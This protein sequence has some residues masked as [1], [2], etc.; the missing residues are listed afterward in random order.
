M[1]DEISSLAEGILDRVM[2]DSVAQLVGQDVYAALAAAKGE[3]FE[4]SDQLSVNLLLGL[5]S[6]LNTLGEDLVE[7][8]QYIKAEL[9]GVM[10]N[11]ILAL[12]AELNWHH[13]MRYLSMAHQAAVEI[14]VAA[15]ST[16]DLIECDK[17][18]NDHGD[19]AFMRG[20]AKGIADAKIAAAKKGAIAR[21]EKYNKLRECFFNWYDAQPASLSESARIE[22]FRREHF[23]L[24]DGRYQW[25]EAV[26]KG[27][28][29]SYNEFP[30]TAKKWLEMRRK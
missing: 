21:D 7:N 24:V 9:V 2:T 6:K 17:A 13:R 1:R 8:E 16:E 25:D 30:R 5:L 14:L 27:I 15:E 11:V 26:R 29:L 10:A 19:A 20:V 22:A 23:K 28:R 4:S 3:I 18:Y 12:F